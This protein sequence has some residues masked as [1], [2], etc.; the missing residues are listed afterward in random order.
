MK[1]G[2]GRGRT[3]A[4]ALGLGLVA[5]IPAW[6]G[7]P[8]VAAPPPG[9]VDAIP[10]GPSLSSRLEDIRRRVQS[11]LVYPP[12]ARERRETGEVV[13]GFAIGSDHRARDVRTVVSSGRPTLDR[14]AERAVVAAAPLPYV[15]G[16][17]QVPVR[18]EL[19]RDSGAR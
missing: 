3:A 9:F 1:A 17:V 11:A 6:A 14:A 12:I 19:D 5:G 10:Q 18:F 13:V 4:L 16:R 15:Y 7:P 8:G 2:R